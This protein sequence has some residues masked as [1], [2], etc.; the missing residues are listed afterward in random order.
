MRRKQQQRWHDG[1]GLRSSLANTPCRNTTSRQSGIYDARVLPNPRVFLLTRHTH[2]QG[3][4][5]YFTNITFPEMTPFCTIG[6]PVW[7]SSCLLG[8]NLRSSFLERA[9][10]NRLHLNAKAACDVSRK[11]PVMCFYVVFSFSQVQPVLIQWPLFLRNPGR[12]SS[13]RSVKVAATEH[14]NSRRDRTTDKTADLG[15]TFN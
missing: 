4:S 13:L 8:L 14:F 5:C 3:S 9:T 7:T 11:Q 10:S 15:S 2:S 6:A 12:G 1:A